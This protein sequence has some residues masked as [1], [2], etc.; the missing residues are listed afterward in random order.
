M[1]GLVGVARTALAPDGQH[2]Q[3]AVRGELW[4]AVSDQ[5]VSAGDE[6]EVTAVDGLRLRVKPYFKKKE[7]RA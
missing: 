7:V 1:I 4:E 5:P 3:L 6:V 2:G